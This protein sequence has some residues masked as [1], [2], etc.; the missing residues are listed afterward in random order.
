[1]NRRLA[2]IAGIVP[3]CCLLS[4][5]SPT[6][7]DSAIEANSAALAGLVLDDSGIQLTL[8]LR[9]RDLPGLRERSASHTP[10]TGACPALCVGV[11]LV[12]LTGGASN[13]PL[14]PPESAEQVT[15]SDG[16]DDPRLTVRYRYPWPERR[17]RL[18]IKPLVAGVDIG[19]VA[20]HEGVP[21]SDMAR[22]DRPAV[23]ELD[24]RNPWRSRYTGVDWRRRHLEPRS[25]L[26]VEGDAVRHEL[27]QPLNTLPATLAPP[28][29]AAADR[30]AVKARIADYLAR[31]N[32]L[33]LNGAPVVP[34]PGKVE[35]VHQS[36]QGIEPVPPGAPVPRRSAMLGMAMVYETTAP[37]RELGLDWKTFGP[38][39]QVHPVQVIYGPETM[40]MD[41]TPAH[42]RLS[43]TEDEAMTRPP[44]EDDA[45]APAPAEPRG[46]LLEGLLFSAYQ[47]FGVRG[48][49]AAYDRFALTLASPLLDDVYLEQRRA[50]L[51][52]D[53][54][55]G[56]ESRVRRVEITAIRLLERARDA[57]RV[58][59]GWIAHGV[60]SH[61]GHAHERH[62]RYRAIVHLRREAGGAWKI[63]ALD[64][65]D[66][67][68]FGDS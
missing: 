61:W 8:R 16:A 53:R 3:A 25:Y 44:G 26:Y 27:A 4:L 7:A 39:E 15:A 55:N 54:G 11:G 33:S 35:F 49:A 46:A 63:H 60:V 45:P 47:A 20:L 6:R 32:P 23:I 30:A 13:E 62:H 40:D 68:R 31:E 36:A 17:N 57:A 64:F 38:G 9:E 24:W 14:G 56:G 50:L 66:G 5:A 2:W 21:V 19:L 22:L 10:A 12:E 67:Q 43:W 52:H 41:V 65:V 34:V 51:A 28:V 29:I 58:D 42:P 18:G 1:M 48:E 37:V 59:A